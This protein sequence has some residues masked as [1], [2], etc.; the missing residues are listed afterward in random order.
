[1]QYFQ[2]DINHVGYICLLISANIQSKTATW[3]KSGEDDVVAHASSTLDGCDC[4][5]Q[6]QIA[7]LRS[8][9]LCSHNWN[10]AHI[11]PTPLGLSVDIEINWCV[12][13]LQ[14]SW[15]CGRL[16]RQ[17]LCHFAAVDAIWDSVVEHLLS[18]E[19]FCEMYWYDWRWRC[20]NVKCD[21]VV[22]ICFVFHNLFYIFWQVK[23]V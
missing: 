11:R 1:M 13:K 3:S 5:S 21:T 10:D 18:S 14:V 19:T 16:Y 9:R 15:G 7:D 6:E 22:V 12:K 8:S 20:G 4:N 23:S 17:F 2:K